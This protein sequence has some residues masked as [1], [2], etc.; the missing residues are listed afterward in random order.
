MAISGENKYESVKYAAIGPWLM[1]T[2]S[3]TF[4]RSIADGPAGIS[5]SRN[6]STRQHLARRSDSGDAGTTH[7]T[8]GSLTYQPLPAVSQT[9]STLRAGMMRKRTES[10][11]ALCMKPTLAVGTSAS[12]APTVNVCR[13][14]LVYARTSVSGLS[15]SQGGCVQDFAKVC[16]ALRDG[17]IHDA[18]FVEEGLTQGRDELQDVYVSG[19]LTQAARM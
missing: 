17:R 11:H 3:A 6:L 8:S 10:T 4:T 12:S 15:A 14:T 9:K 19:C 2:S 5:I 1:S 13:T 7:Q 18:V 16:D